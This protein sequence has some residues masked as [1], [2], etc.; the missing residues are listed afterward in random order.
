RGTTQLRAEIDPEACYLVAVAPLRGEGQRFALGAE[1]PHALR[2]A[3]NS[4]PGHGTSLQFCSQGAEQV[5]LETQ[6][7]GSS[8]AWILGVWRLGSGPLA[9]GL[10]ERVLP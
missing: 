9:T 1:L 6:A 10:I 4:Q 5:N 8:L 7:I 2:E 3:Q